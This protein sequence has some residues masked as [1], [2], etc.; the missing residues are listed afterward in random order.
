M[1]PGVVIP[2]A[3]G[4]M[5]VGWLRGFRL[6]INKNSLRY[7]D[8]LYRTV[9]VPVKEILEVRNTWVE[10]RLLTRSLRVPRLVVAYGSSGHR[11][12][13]NT[14]PFLRR[15]IRRAID[16]LRTSAANTLRKTT[17]RQPT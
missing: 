13:I 5:W 7:R 12:V 11:L 1:K 6:E 9:A 3:V 17:A 2:F 8:G 15:D 14:K 10:W 4:M 16:M